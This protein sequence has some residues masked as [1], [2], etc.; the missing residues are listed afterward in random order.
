MMLAYLQLQASLECLASSPIYLSLPTMSDNPLLVHTK[1]TNIDNVLPPVGELLA[2]LDH[3]I[4]NY[5]NLDSEECKLD[6]RELAEAD[7]HPIPLPVDREGYGTV[8]LTPYHWATGHCDWLN[9]QTAMERHLEPRAEQPIRL[10]DFGCATGRFLRHVAAFGGEKYDAWGC[11]FA[12]ENINW[13]KRHFPASI[14]TFLNNANPHLPF[15]DNYFDVIAAFS[16]FT[17][18]DQFEDA[19]LLELRRIT[20]PGGL[21]YLTTQNDAM[22]NNYLE[23]S[24]AVKHLCRANKIKSNKIHVDE[25]LFQS[26][27]PEDRIVFRMSE[28]HV[29]NCNVWHSDDYL[30]ANWGRYF[31]IHAICNQA[32]NRLQSPVLLRPL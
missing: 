7:P 30:R 6:F 22:W 27:M 11:D 23:N 13:N 14:K 20:Q 32:H 9:V 17:H 5:R 1:A 2:E 4:I 18:I 12:V 26:P 16:V 28:G 21:L 24:Y 15:P 8:A 3:T 25:A 31:K 29:Y 19:W 10:L